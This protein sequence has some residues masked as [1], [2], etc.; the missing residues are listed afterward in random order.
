[1]TETSATSGMAIGIDFLSVW[2]T[3]FSHVLKQVSGKTVSCSVITTGPPV[4][5]DGN[6]QDLWIVAA[7]S[8][9]LRGEMSLRL[10]SQAAIFLAAAL[11]GESIQGECTDE[12]R[13]AALELI[14]QVA[15]LVA[16]TL[17][18]RWGE[19]HLHIE[20]TKAAPAWPPA[21]TVWLSVGDSP[22]SAQSIQAHLSAA[23]LAALRAETAD[24]APAVTFSPASIDDSW[25]AN[26]ADL[27]LLMDVEL[28]VTLRFGRRRLLLREVL[29]LTPGAVLEL[30][31]Q[32][33][34]PVEMVLDGRLLARGEVVVLNGNYA[35]RITEVES[36]HGR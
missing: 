15:G 6:D 5:T 7:S 1:M 32:V 20:A 29:E 26:K 21:S 13:D 19:V 25:G 18:P 12:H 36:G 35:L 4:S 9:G 16:T 2:A 24:A 17:K 27:G 28:G 22:E 23:L 33:R 30:D 10:T 8:G 34:E 14:R 3:S 31:R 11:M